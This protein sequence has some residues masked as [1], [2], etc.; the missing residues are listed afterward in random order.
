[1]SKILFIGDPHIRHTHL[2]DGIDLF[3]W[4]ES[5]VEVEKPDLVVNLGDTLDDHSVLH[6]EVLS[7]VNQHLLR[8]RENKVPVVMVL[9]NHDMWKPNC[10]KYHALEVFKSYKGVLVAD[11][12]IIADGITYT[13]YLPTSSSWPDTSTDI[14]V[15][16]NTFIGA[17]YGPSCAKDGIDAAQVQ[18]DLVV[19]GHIHKRQ[20]LKEGLIVYPGTPSSLTASDA[21]Q[22]KG[23]MILDSKTLE[24]RFI[25]S[26]FPIWRTLDVYLDSSNKLELNEK[27][28]W[29]VKLIGPRAE[30]KSFLES[31]TV[32][33]LKKRIQVSF[34]AEFTDS[35]KINRTQISAPTVYS[36][37]EQYID[38]VY[39]GTMDRTSLKETVKK[40]TEQQ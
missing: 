8:L 5:V 1:M 10:N 38:K 25:D 23:L 17:D 21:N 6:A 13:P 12:T 11:K 24:M 40:Y 39:S 2:K 9:G 37:A 30:V 31:K 26:P 14:V 36:M 16:H 20:S 15:T 27:D 7:I 28:R 4:I 32:L 35:I 19:S 33:D 22:V 34:K 18:A 3:R 29:I